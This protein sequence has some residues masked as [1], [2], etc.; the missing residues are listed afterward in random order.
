MQVTHNSNASFR[1]QFISLFKRM[2]LILFDLVYFNIVT[3]VVLDLCIIRTIRI[4]FI[5][6]QDALL[7]CLKKKITVNIEIWHHYLPSDIS[8]KHRSDIYIEKVTRKQFNFFSIYYFEVTFIKSATDKNSNSY[9]YNTY[10]NNY[11]ND[12]N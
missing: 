6:F 2:S 12:Y 11:N 8:R 9:N 5:R 4:Y 10:N 1:Y 7:H 3:A